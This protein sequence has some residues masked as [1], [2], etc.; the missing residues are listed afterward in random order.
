MT[1]LQFRTGNVSVWPD[2]LPSGRTADGRG[3]AYLDEQLDR[4]Y[5]LIPLRFPDPDRTD[6][7]VA[8][9]YARYVTKHFEEPHGE[10]LDRLSDEHGLMWL[11][12]AKVAQVSVPALRKWRHGGNPTSENKLALARLLA[13]CGRLDELG[14]PDAAA[15]LNTPIR[16]DQ[17]RQRV[18]LLR[19]PEGGETLLALAQDKISPSRALDVL[20]PTWRERHAKPSSEVTMDADGFGTVHLAEI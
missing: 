16:L 7:P 18:E 8:A 4:D 9:E 15:W 3:A 10:L 12:I 13:A 11:T 6:V 14:V 19:L 1:T 17:N 5:R 2:N 20:D